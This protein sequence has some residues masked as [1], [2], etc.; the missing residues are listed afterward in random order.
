VS[1]ACL[2]LAYHIDVTG[3]SP[4]THPLK[5]LEHGVVDGPET[6]AAEIRGEREGYTCC[7]LSL[8]LPIPSQSFCLPPYYAA[9]ASCRDNGRANEVI[10]RWGGPKDLPR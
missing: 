5:C 3:Q 9:D 8:E 2:L 6:I 7:L 10:C 4:T 1:A